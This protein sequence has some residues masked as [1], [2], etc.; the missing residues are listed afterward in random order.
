MEILKE[1]IHNLE[2]KIVIVTG[3]NCGIG[4][5]A[6]KIFAN[7]GAKVVL[8]CRDD[9]RGRNAEELIGNGSKY[10]NLDLTSFK[11][12]NNFSKII[13]SEFGS[14]DILLNNA[15][16][17]FPPFTKTDEGLELTFAINYIGYFYLTLKLLDL[18]KNVKNSRIVNVS[19]IA[20]YSAKEINFENLNSEQNYDKA[21]TYNLVNLLRVMFTMELEKKLREKEMETIAVACHPGVAKTNLTRH[22]PGFLKKGFLLNIVFSTFFM[23]AYEGALPLVIAAA[24]TNV[25][26][27]DFVGIDSKRQM[28]GSPKITKPNDLVFDDNLRIKLWNNT[29]EIT[30][31]YF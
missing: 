10:I 26:G 31:L 28:K 2:N 29:Q 11:N 21:S 20:H 6:A 24:G 19:S 7:Q 5:E 1:N 23:S 14:I 16:V 13:K 25:K 8:A 4:F 27:G 3:S 15:G 17:M 9:E 30:G 22:L 18:I 12:I